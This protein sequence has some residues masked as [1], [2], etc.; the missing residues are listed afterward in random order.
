MVVQPKDLRE[1]EKAI[2]KGIQ[3]KNVV[4][5]IGRCS[6]EYEG[7]SESRLSEGERLVIIKEDGAFIVHRP[8]GYAPVNWQPNTSA[9]RVE[10]AEDTLVV[11]AIRS[12]PR[13]IVR[14]FFSDVKAVVMGKLVDTGEF[15]M[16]LDEHEI[17]DLIYEEPWIVEEGLKIIEKEKKLP[18]GSIDL[19][20]YDSSGK[21]VIIEI[22]RVTASRDAVLQLYKYVESYAR[23]YGVKPRGILVAPSLSQKAIETA[24]KLGLE[25]KVVN[26]QKLWKMKKEKKRVGIGGEKSILDFFR[27]QD[28]T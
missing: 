14:V 23:N 25:Y 2:K 27:K 6:I 28:S 19:F 17:R 18:V 9:I 12:S 15:I 20:G 3:N 1:A 24:E 13:E 4:I 7:R 10:H 5:I 11:T 26:I 8:T 22:K 16:Y 21:P